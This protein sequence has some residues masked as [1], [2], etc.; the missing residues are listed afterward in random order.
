MIIEVMGLAGWKIKTYSKK[1]I[2]IDIEHAK[3]Y[4]R[5]SGSRSL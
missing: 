5:T 3:D 1:V 2:E 4:K